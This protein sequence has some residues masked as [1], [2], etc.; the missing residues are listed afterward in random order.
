MRRITAVAVAA[1]A[2]TLPAC[3]GSD[4]P[5]VADPD[6]LRIEVVSGDRQSAP[7]RPAT[8]A[9]VGGL[10][11]LDVPL[12]PNLL[13]EPLVA[14]VTIAGAAPAGGIVGPAFAVLPRDVSVTFR[15]VQPVG[16]PHGR[17]CGAS[18]LDSAI[19]DDSAH[20]TTYWERGT[21]AGVECRMEVRLVVDGVPRVDTAFVAVFEPG[22][23]VAV[24]SQ[25]P[26]A[27][28]TAGDSIWIPD[29]LAA[30]RDEHINAIPLAH[31]HEYG[32]VAWAWQQRGAAMPTEP[33]GTGWAT[34]APAEG[35][36]WAGETYNAIL[37]LWI[38]GT[39]GAPN[40]GV[41]LLVR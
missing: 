4:D 6:D 34:R 28:V 30:A 21:L 25:D 38:G 31:L 13:P 7:V 19:P 40:D 14:R 29:V 8:S 37:R 39:D 20:V 3:S 9:P 17:D 26:P 22:P 5:D 36:T 18:F 32:E 23:V 12:P 24:S 2:L 33:Q 1:L 41:P 15:V 27:A 16:D 35:A 11:A 10:V